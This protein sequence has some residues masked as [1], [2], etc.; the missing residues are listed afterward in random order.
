MLY[1]KINSESVN[2]DAN[3]KNQPNKQ[4]KCTPTVYNSPREKT[5]DNFCVFG[6]GKNFL[7]KNFMF[8][9]MHRAIK[10][11]IDVTVSYILLR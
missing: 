8:Y 2:R 11:K 1:W 4:T 6:L 9:V 3:V 7:T 10:E 5:G